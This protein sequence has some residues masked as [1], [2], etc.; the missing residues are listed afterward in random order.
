M[1]TIFSKKQFDGYTHRFKVQFVATGETYFS[2]LDIYSN[3]DS[4]QKIEDFIN[5][6]KTEKV[7][8]FKII[9][10]VSKEQDELAEK[11]INETLDGI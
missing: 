3:T 5:E 2:C 6:K 11:F 10:R 9:N 7:L 4:F 8:S 1:E